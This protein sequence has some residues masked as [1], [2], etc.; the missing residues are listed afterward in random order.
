MCNVIFQKQTHT[1]TSKARN[2]FV[3]SFLRKTKNTRKTQ[4][5]SNTLTTQRKPLKRRKS[6][7]SGK[8]INSK[9]LLALLLGAV[10]FW[11]SMMKNGSGSGSRIGF[12]LFFLSISLRHL[13]I[14]V[15]VV[16][17]IIHFFLGGRT[18]MAMR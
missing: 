2:M 10:G 12:C 16:L 9:L 13:S 15:S 11:A 1:C 18:I 14:S 17:Y 6:S 3:R 7:S 4:P 5:K 8:A